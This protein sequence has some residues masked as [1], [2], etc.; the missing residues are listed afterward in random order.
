MRLIERPEEVLHM[1]PHLVR[2]HVGVGKVSPGAELRLHLVKEGEVYIQ[3]LVRRAVE[4]AHL[5]RRPTAATLHRIGIEHHPRR[6]V[7][8]AILRKDFR[9]GILRPLEDHLGK[10]GHLLLLGRR[11]IRLLLSRLLRDDLAATLPQ[12]IEGI[13]PQQP[14]DQPDDDQTPDAHTGTLDPPTTPILYVTA[15]LSSVQSHI[16]FFVKN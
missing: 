1:V 8:L 16:L 9:P 14:G 3:S 5:R 15:L 13:A 6:R 7:G 2:D 10:G 11:A 12:H 4:G